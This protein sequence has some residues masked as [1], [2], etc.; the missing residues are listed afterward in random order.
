MI[1]WLVGQAGIGG[2]A[3]FALYTLNTNHQQALRR[4]QEYAA[5]NREDK[6]QLLRV[7]AE[8]TIAVTKLTAMIEQL[9]H[10]KA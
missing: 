4:E 7:M 1:Q 10:G 9:L 6:L 2:L 8:N 5:S 3:A